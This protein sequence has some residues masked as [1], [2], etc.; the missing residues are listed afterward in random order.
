VR[1][2]QAAE[3]YKAGD[4]G[5]F[6]VS[7]QIPAN[8]IVDTTVFTARAGN[9]KLYLLYVQY[10]RL[11]AERLTEAMRPFHRANLSGIGKALVI[12]A[13]D[14]DDK[15]PPKLQELVEEDYIEPKY[16]ESPR[17][18][19]GFEGP[20][21][22]YIAGLSTSSEPGNVV[23]YENP[24]FCSE[25]INVLF[26]DTHVEAMR[27]AGFLEDLEATYKRLGREMPEIWAE[28]REPAR[29]EPKVPAA[30]SLKVFG[31]FQES[32]KVKLSVLG[33]DS[34]ELLA[35]PKLIASVELKLPSA[36]GGNA[37]LLKEWATAQA[38]E[39]TVRILDSP[40]TNYYQYCLLQSKEKYGL[41]SNMQG[42][43][44]KKPDLELA[45]QCPVREIKR[46]DEIPIIFTITNR[47]SS[48]YFYYEQVGS[49]D[50]RLHLME[51]YELIA[52]REDGTVV[53]DPLGRKYSGGYGGSSPPQDGIGPGESFSR[54]VPLNQF[55]LITE[56][57]RYMIKGVYYTG[58]YHLSSDFRRAL[59]VI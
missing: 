18:P 58:I 19:R 53:L 30:R 20:S 9:E 10:P 32:G 46:G 22:I 15:Y 4:V 5:V 35:K 29:P 16:L 11:V 6:S 50:D 59:S 3:Y 28:A 43:E 47:G 56:P 34:A 45:I 13:N 42:G 31:R 36:D 1:A 21:Y 33:R 49:Y 38:K 40:H 25:K 12:Y 39:Y 27:P 44:G 23:A 57:G 24:D 17:E 51:Q 14:H 55:A 37:E 7:V 52:R 41:A 48:E 54:A 8:I 26:M 2:E